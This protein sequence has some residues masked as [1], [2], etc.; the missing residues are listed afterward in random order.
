MIRKLRWLDDQLDAFLRTG[1]SVNFC[2]GGVCN[3]PSRVAATAARTRTSARP[4][5]PASRRAHVGARGIG[6]RRVN[7]RHRRGLLEEARL[8]IA[9]VAGPAAPPLRMT[10]RLA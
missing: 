4:D 10:T 8:A 2:P 6:E 5:A 3:F 1:E 7:H 9:E